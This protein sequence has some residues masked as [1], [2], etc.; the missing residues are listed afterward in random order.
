MGLCFDDVDSDQ[1]L[2][3]YLHIYSVI[4]RQCLYYTNTNIYI[5]GNLSKP[6]LLVTNFHVQNRHMF[7]LYMLN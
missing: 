7:S 1:S 5:Q 6:N 3:K 4:K 2:N